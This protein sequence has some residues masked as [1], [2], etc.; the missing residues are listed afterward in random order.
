MCNDN[1]LGLQLQLFASQDVLMSSVLLPQASAADL[2]GP[3]VGSFKGQVPADHFDAAV[4][5][6]APEQSLVTASSPEHAQDSEV[7]H[8]CP[9]QSSKTCSRAVAQLNMS[10]QLHM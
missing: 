2:G 7:G 1:W 8:P 3:E 10:L 6:A 4:A 9:Q 5:L